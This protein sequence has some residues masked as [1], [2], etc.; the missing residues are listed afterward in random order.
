VTFARPLRKFA[1]ATHITVSVGWIGAVLAYLALGL[2]SVAG[3]DAVTARAA[4]SAMLVIGWW[5][6]VPLGVA[7][8]ATGVV[9]SVGTPWGL[10]RHYWVIVSL[11]LTTV[12]LAILLLHMP[13][14][15]TLAL[16]AR[17][18]DDRQLR[19]LG[20]DLMHPGVG[21]LVL[22]SVTWLNVYKPAGVTPYGWRTQRERRATL[23]APARSLPAGE[24]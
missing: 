7:S 1:L 20:G 15:S 12:S 16:V 21:L 11:A 14:V 4:W 17:T 5:V 24:N 10:F 18:V 23:E 8:W 22:L 13:A 6:I 9:V 19:T 3:Q 2:A